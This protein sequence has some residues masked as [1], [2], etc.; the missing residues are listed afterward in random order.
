MTQVAV[1]LDCI[2]RGGLAGRG[3]GVLY[4]DGGGASDDHGI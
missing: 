4:L 2:S 1:G 3:E